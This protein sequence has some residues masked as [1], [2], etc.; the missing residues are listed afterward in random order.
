M[1]LSLYGLRNLPFLPNSRF[2]RAIKRV[3]GIFPNRLFYYHKACIHKSVSYEL[4]GKRIYNERLE[5]LGD[6][7]LDAVVADYLFISFFDEDEGTLSKLRSKIVNRENLNRIAIQLGVEGMLQSKIQHSG[8]KNV[9]GNALE[10]LLGAVYLDRGYKTARK[11]ILKRIVI[12]NHD[13]SQLKHDD[14]DYKSQLIEWGQKNNIAVS[15]QDFEKYSNTLNEQV[16]A[17]TIIVNQNVQGKGEGRS[18]KEAEQYAAKEVI[19]KIEAGAVTDQ[20]FQ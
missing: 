1:N 10:A 12:P 19:K 15:F 16:F 20:H 17:S 11:C 13:L 4:K 18:K 6:A 9:C 3:L 2:R 7:I 5:F 8:H 14:T